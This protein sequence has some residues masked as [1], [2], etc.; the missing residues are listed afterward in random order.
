MKNLILSFN[1][2]NFTGNISPEFS[3]F[4][5]KLK[6]YLSAFEEGY[7]LAKQKYSDH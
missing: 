7:N 1:F 2:S 6:L 5:E 3:S 4:E